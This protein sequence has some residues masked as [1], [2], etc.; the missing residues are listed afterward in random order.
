MMLQKNPKSRISAFE[1]INHS[2]F[3]GS[4][5]DLISNT[6]LTLNYKENVAYNIQNYQKECKL[7]K[8]IKMFNVKLD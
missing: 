1:A 2:W 5:E 8:A 4:K 6:T 7:Q 3:K